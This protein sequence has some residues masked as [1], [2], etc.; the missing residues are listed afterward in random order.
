MKDKA[1]Q[2]TAGIDGVKSVDN[3]LVVKPR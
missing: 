1:G 2:I 3:A